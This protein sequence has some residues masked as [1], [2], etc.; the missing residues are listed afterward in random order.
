MTV[1]TPKTLDEILA[2]IGIE[3]NSEYDT[4]YTNVKK[5]FVEW[6]ES[7]IPEK[8]KDE[9]LPASPM[10]ADWFEMGY[11]KAIEKQ[12]ACIEKEGHE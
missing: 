10:M 9:E 7:L 12:R 11:D 4:N 2:I 3:P 8:L 1:K 5:M 6:A